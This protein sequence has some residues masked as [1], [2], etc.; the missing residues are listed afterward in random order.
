MRAWRKGVELGLRDI[1]LRDV[2]DSDEED[3]LNDFYIP[4]L[5]CSTE[6]KRLAGF[7]SSSALAAAA[8]GVSGFIKNRGQMR[9]I[10]GAKLRKADVEAI[11]SGIEDRERVISRMMINVLDNLESGFFKDHVRALAWMVAQNKLEIKVAIPMNAGKITHDIGIYHPK[12]GILSDDDNPRNTI[13]FSGSINESATGW[14]RNLEEFK[15]F[16][17]WVGAQNAYLKADIAAFGKYWSGNPKRAMVIDIPTAVRKKLIEFAPETFDELLLKKHYSPTHS[18][19]WKHQSD[20]V[21]SWVDNDYRGIFAM[22]TGTGKTLAALS[23][24]G[25]PGSASVTIILVPTIPLLEQWGKKDIISY[26]KDADIV[27]CGGKWRWKTIL[28]LKLAALRKRNEDYTPKHRLYVVATMRTAA[29][30]GFL[31][32]WSGIPASR[33]QIICD[34]VHH[35]GAPT[36]QDCTKIPSTR[37]LGLSATPDR[38]WDDEGTQNTIDYIG[39][40]VCEYSIA[41]AIRDEHLA[42]YNYYPYFSFLTIPEWED[43]KEKSHEIRR[44]AA[45]INATTKDPPKDQPFAYKTHKLERLLMER[46]IIKKKAKDKIRVIQDILRDIEAFPIIVFC[47]DHEQLD[48]IKNVMKS[49]ARSFLMYYSSQPGKKMSMLERSKTLEQFRRGNSEV[50]LAMKCLD[51]GLDIPK[52]KGCIIVASANSTR[53]FIQRRGRILRELKGKT[54]FLYDIIVL[55][56]KAAKGR[57]LAAE[58]LIKQEC[59]RVGNLV[60]GANNEWNVR[61]RIR[62]ELKPYGMAHMADF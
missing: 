59:T 62:Q 19:L 15:V 56:P 44:E 35:L 30:K 58:T 49:N 10:V 29:S 12:V 13:S 32:T 48:S 53:Q 47:E 54:A 4:A 16:R 50:L 55:P 42:P 18:T 24:S 26:D 51:E 14:R 34:E 46:A 45:R 25:L 20:A 9:L 11:K 38:N 33:V 40:T 43:Y 57:G 22:A 31:L 3:I 17:S 8:K 6:Y 7:F 52:C 61:E 39:K 2:Y 1:P 41:E 5:S 27:M 28:P 60:N 21:R 23:A 37:R 36:Y